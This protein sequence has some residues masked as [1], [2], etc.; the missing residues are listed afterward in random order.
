MDDI[1]W[2]PEYATQAFVAQEPLEELDEIDGGDE[3]TVLID[4]DA[5][6]MTWWA[7]NCELPAHQRLFNRLAAQNWPGWQIETAAC[8]ATAGFGCRTKGERAMKRMSAFAAL[9]CLAAASSALAGTPAGPAAC[10]VEI[11]PYPGRDRAM[12]DGL[13]AARDGRVYSGLISEGESAHLYVYD[14]ATGPQRAAV[15]HGRVPR[16]ARPGNPHL[17]QDPQQA[18]RGR[19][20][21]S[22]LRA[23]EQR[24]RAADRSTSPV[25][26]ADT[27]S[28]TTPARGGWRTWAWST[29]A[30]ASTR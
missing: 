29:R 1:F 20:G 12:W 16:R 8:G 18:G 2:G 13:Y 4:W 11:R 22:L 5:K 19:P 24:Q 27:G 21:Q 30:P 23:A 10:P 25:G 7:A 26:G 15:R 14:P 3:G 28:A 6:R 9:V 17:G